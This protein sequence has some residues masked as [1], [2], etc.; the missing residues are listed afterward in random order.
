M[1]EC[2]TLRWTPPNARPRR[3]RLEP[4]AA[5]GWTRIEQE[6]TDE[7]EWRTVGQEIVADVELDAPAAIVSDRNP[8]VYHGP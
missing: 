3:I 2:I 7:G 1:H 4:R 5:G 8:S 6:R